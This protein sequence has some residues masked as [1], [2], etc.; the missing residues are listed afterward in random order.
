MPMLTIRTGI[1]VCDCCGIANANADTS[2][3]E[4][5]CEPGHVDRLCQ[6]GTEPGEDV[7]PDDSLDSPTLT[8]CY[9]CGDDAMCSLTVAVLVR[10]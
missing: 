6:W 3:C 4:F 2:G 7:V 10:A 9:G 1:P 8:R 5:W